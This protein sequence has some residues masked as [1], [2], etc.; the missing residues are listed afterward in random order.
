MSLMNFKNQ[1]YLTCS[2]LKRAEVVFVVLRLPHTSRFFIAPNWVD[3]WGGI[4][5]NQDVAPIPLA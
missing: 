2:E 1:I 5:Q 4:S 3:A